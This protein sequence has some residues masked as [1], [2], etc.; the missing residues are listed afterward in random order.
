MTTTEATK[1]SAD[2]LDGRDRYV[3][4]WINAH[5]PVMYSEVSGHTLD[6]LL[7]LELVKLNPSRH[8]RASWPVT[9]TE[10]G[11]QVADYIRTF[12]TVAPTKQRASENG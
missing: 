9:C 11:K 4:L 10:L 5:V 3:L 7:A 12:K 6:T 1:N 2:K 8:P